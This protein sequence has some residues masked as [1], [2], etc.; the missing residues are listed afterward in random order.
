MHTLRRQLT[1]FL[2]NEDAQAIEALRR[3]YNPVQ[4]GLI[5]SHV[6]LYRE[7]ELASWAVVQENLASLAFAPFTLT[8]GAPERFWEGKGVF[9][10]LAD[11]SG[12]FRQLRKVVLEGAVPEPRVHEAHITLL[13]PRNATCDDATFR[14]IRQAAIPARVSIGRISLIEQQDGGPWQTL[15]SYPLTQAAG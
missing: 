2:D 7:D 9:L 1:L 10:P 15:A 8:V 3:R 4:F 6:T 5:G 12:H 13:H 14:A 11:E